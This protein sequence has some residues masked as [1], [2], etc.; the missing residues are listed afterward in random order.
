MNGQHIEKQAAYNQN[1][2]RKL[3]INVLKLFT[4]VKISEKSC[5]GINYPSAALFKMSL[6]GICINPI[7]IRIS[8]IIVYIGSSF[9]L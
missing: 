6:N 8:T 5:G 7:L 2:L 9:A 1:I 3:A 4:D